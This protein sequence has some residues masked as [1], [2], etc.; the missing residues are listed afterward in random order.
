VLRRIGHTDG[1]VYTNSHHWKL[2][3]QNAAKHTR[4]KA[5][6][7]R[8]ESADWL[9]PNKASPSFCFSP[10]RSASSFCSS[11]EKGNTWFR[12]QR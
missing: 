10:L 7:V 5:K 12:A 1:D 2:P 4:P 3:Q 11:R 8:E 6:G 9:S